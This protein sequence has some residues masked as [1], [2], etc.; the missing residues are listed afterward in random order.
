MRVDMF[1]PHHCIAAFILMALSAV[2]QAKFNFNFM[3]NPQKLRIRE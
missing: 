1:L 3:W 2:V